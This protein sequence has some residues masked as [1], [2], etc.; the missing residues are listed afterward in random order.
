MAPHA[1]VAAVAAGGAG[2]GFSGGGFLIPFFLG[3][4]DV[5]YRDLKVFNH[6]MPVAG[7]ST[8]A[9]ATS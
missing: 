6:S 5:L 9:I 8:G 1:A 2:V 7:A 3:V 4:I